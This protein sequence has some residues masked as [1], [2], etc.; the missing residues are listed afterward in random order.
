MTASNRDGVLY[1]SLISLAIAIVVLLSMTLTF[2]GIF[3]VGEASFFNAV[4][5]WKIVV[6]IVSGILSGFVALKFSVRR[7]LPYFAAIWFIGFVIWLLAI[8]FL[9]VNI[10]FPA[11][12]LITLSTIFA[13]HARKIWAIDSELTEKLVSLASSGHLLG[14]KSA[15]LRI[16]SGLKLLETVL[17]LSEAI[18]FSYDSNGAL[19]PIGRA[20]T[21]KAGDCAVSR[22]SSW[23]DNIQLCEEALTGRQTVVQK[24]E[25]DSKSARIALPLIDDGTIVGVLFVSCQQNFE[26]ED[27]NI[28]EAFS[29]QI[30][31][32]FQR[33]QLRGKSLPHKFWWSF[34]STQSAENRL[35]I[36][37]LINGI[38]KEQSFGALA[39]SHLKEAHAIAYLD[40]TLAYLNRKMRH[41]AQLSAHDIY[42]TDLFSLLDR[43]KTYIFNEPSLAIR[44]V[45]QTG[46]TYKCELYF[47]ETNKTL[48]L[49]ISLVKV[50]TNEESIHESNISMKPA[51]FLIT[52][53][54]I[55]A[56]KE[57]EKLRSDMTSL[58]SHELRTP[59]TSIRGFA[60][61]LLADETMSEESI[62]FLTIISN[63]SQRLSKMLTTF[64]SVS[65]LEQSDKQDVSK[66]P[67]KLDNVVSEVVHG[68]KEAAKL[69]R[70][71][72]VEQAN[73]H[74][75]PVAADKGLIVRA[76]SNLV[77]NAIRY[78]PERTSVIISTILESDVL[79]VVVEDRGYGIPKGEQEKIWEKFY[80]VARDGQDKEEE[81]TGLGLS[82]VKEIVEQHGGD[83]TVESEL[84]GGSK[85]SF[86]L[87]RL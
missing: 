11:F 60:E 9:D 41:I 10:L 53:R 83:V 48:K 77:D 43:F 7:I 72:L 3:Y 69:K 34:L 4:S 23:R 78:S 82:L 19:N 63:E 14:G 27:L 80:R 45:L 86:T 8:K 6:L 42:E 73:T 76:L 37:N 40:G 68:L 17:P 31:R 81:S 5:T 70:I 62:E 18:V 65:N 56:L 84:G 46:E 24:D 75:P 59:I 57:N 50:P 38:I 22:Q 55:T 49:Q 85:F 13:I 28:L 29:D 30:A 54:D 12:F 71:R 20:R 16:E 32:N 35:D 25:S 44:R 87:P 66:T 74:L 64:L 39:S 1:T 52:L 47:P 58:M 15:D 21:D 67:I 51:C 26:A 36:I 33:K 61:I 79:R 2:A